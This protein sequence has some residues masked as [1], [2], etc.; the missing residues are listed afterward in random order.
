MVST[1]IAITFEA[2]QVQ[3]A[4]EGSDG[5]E[6]GG[7]DGYPGFNKGPDH[8]CCACDFKVVSLGI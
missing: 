7:D 1:V 5:D 4:E 6:G 2:R 3:G 8:R